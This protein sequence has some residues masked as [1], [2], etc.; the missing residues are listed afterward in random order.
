MI[1]IIFISPGPWRLVT[2]DIIGPLARTKRG[3][4][5]I[6]AATDHFTKWAEVRAIPDKSMLSVQEFVWEIIC[7]NG[8]MQQLDSDQGREFVNQLVEMTTQLM[9]I[10]H[11]ISSAYHPQTQVKYFTSNF[12]H[13]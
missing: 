6:V 3:N 1:L 7:R 13:E 9:D 2:I 11:R 8:P 10:E 12:K 5:Y 4:Q